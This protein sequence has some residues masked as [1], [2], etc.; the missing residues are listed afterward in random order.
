[1]KINRGLTRKMKSS[2]L[3]SPLRCPWCMSGDIESPSSPAVDDGI[4]TQGV[5]CSRCGKCWSDIYR[6]VN[7]RE[8]V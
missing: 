4:A 8:D 1:M 5:K 7:I 6:L 3:N 2:Y